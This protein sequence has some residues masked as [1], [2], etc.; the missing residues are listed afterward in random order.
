MKTQREIEW[1]MMD[2]FRQLSEEDRAAA[3]AYAQ[4][5][6]AKAAGGGIDHREALRRRI[7]S[8]CGSV[9]AFAKEL[10]YASPAPISLRLKGK[11]KWN[12]TSMLKAKEVLGLTSEEFD[13][14][15][16]NPA[17]FEKNSD[18]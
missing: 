7:V 17:E 2:Q 11:R 14:F 1:E 10:G 12:S 15:F 13:Y 8:K 18:T 9:G 3:L 6:A 5:L 4:G 16:F